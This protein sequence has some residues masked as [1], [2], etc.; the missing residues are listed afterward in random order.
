MPAANTTTTQPQVHAISG[1]GGGA[2]TEN[3][4]GLAPGSVATAAVITA[5]CS[6]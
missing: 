3:G 4:L 6:A 1:P 5:G 2:V